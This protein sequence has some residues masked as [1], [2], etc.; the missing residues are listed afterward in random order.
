MARA[1]EYAAARAANARNV[2]RETEEQKLPPKAAPI[3]LSA[4]TKDQPTS[5]NKGNKTWKPLTADDLGG[6]EGY[7]DNPIPTSRQQTPFHPDTGEEPRDSRRLRPAQGSTEELKIPTAPR[8]MLVQRDRP[9][10]LL[11]P[12]S[13]HVSAHVS[14]HPVI[15]FPSSQNQQ[16][17]GGTPGRGGQGRLLFNVPQFPSRYSRAPRRA[18]LREIQSLGARVDQD[19]LQPVPQ[20]FR[21]KFDPASNFLTPTR[22]EIAEVMRERDR[23]HMENM[24]MINMP[25]GATQQQGPPFTVFDDSPLRYYNPAGYDL[26]AYG[27]LQA[28]NYEVTPPSYYPAQQNMPRNDLAPTFQSTPPTYRANPPSALYH[29]EYR[30]PDIPYDRAQMMEKYKATLT[31]EALE[32]KGKTVLH[33]PELHKHQEQQGVVKTNQESVT[34]GAPWQDV[35]RMLEESKRA[36]EAMVALRGVGESI[37]DA[38]KNGGSRMQEDVFAGSD[39]TSKIALKGPPPGLSLPTD[40]PGDAKDN[41][42]KEFPDDFY[43]LKPVSM[44]DV[45]EVQATSQRARDEIAGT[46]KQPLNSTKDGESVNAVRARDAEAWFYGTSSS[47]NGVPIDVVAAKMHESAIKD[48]A[49]KEKGEE[50]MAKERALIEDVIKNVTYYYEEARKPEDKRTFIFKIAPVPEYARERPTVQTGGTSIFSSFFEEPA[51]KGDAEKAFI[52]T[53]NRLARDP[54]YRLAAPAGLMVKTTRPKPDLGGGVW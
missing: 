11:N 43:T 2:S 54:R 49:L 8:A 35:E 48:K 28:P 34:D 53:P 44:K 52:P 3:S 45:R 31:K 29:P 23:Q 30:K 32:R 27:Q 24:Q 15:N 37:Y 22:D 40:G 20:M 1:A 5:R 16:I 6:D 41:G 36:Q 14:A 50:E 13:R 12:T 18:Y 33:N 42:L 4:F 9:A 38:Y 47:E 21:N 19:D 51:T 17:P 46:I 26:S 25:P 7:T 39:N 10:V